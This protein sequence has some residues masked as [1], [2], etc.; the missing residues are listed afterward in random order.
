MRTRFTH[1][2]P[3]LK[4]WN[5]IPDSCHEILF[6]NDPSKCCRGEKAPS[7]VG[8]ELGGAICTE[9]GSNKV[10]VQIFVVYPGKERCQGAPVL[11]TAPS[12]SRG[13]S[14]VYQ[15]IFVGE[16]VTVSRL[17]FV[18]V[19]LDRLSQNRNNIVFAQHSRV[20]EGVVPHLGAVLR[21]GKRAVV[22]G[23]VVTLGPFFIETV[24]RRVGVVEGPCRAK[25]E[26]WQDHVFHIGCPVEVLANPVIPV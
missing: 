11:V 12:Y 26:A 24:R 21:C 4:V 15:N 18:V 25:L 16:S 1:G 17:G 23:R 8:P 22:V 14:Y 2:C 5:R 3:Q 10:A 20:I 7:V 6:G 9:C 13:T 19:C